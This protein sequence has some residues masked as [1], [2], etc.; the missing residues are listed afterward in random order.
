MGIDIQFAGQLIGLR[1][2]VPASGDAVMLGRQSIHIRPRQ[3]GRLRRLLRAGGLSDD[4]SDYLQEDGFS[5]RFF[6]AIGYPAMRSMDASGYEG[7]DHV[8]DLN[9]PLAAAHRGAFDLVIDGGTIEHV[10]NAPQALDSVFH[11]LRDGGVFISINGMTGWPGHGF[12]QF[13]P[14]LV[15]RYWGQA[16]GCEVLRCIA[17]P[18]DPER[19]IVDAPDTAVAGQRFR[20]RGLD[21]R[22]Y[23]FYAVRKPAGANP[24]ERV[25]EV[26]Q[27]D[28]A[29]RW[30]RKDADPEAAGA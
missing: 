28:Y 2:V 25:T 8:Q 18:F 29:V 20:G 9:A 12:Y 10:F 22:W 24:A 15:W 13:S 27:G 23:L 11:M 16:R 14:D 21:G 7:C 26:A 3:Y 1:D 6:E 4:V 5:E 17:L 19:G 30:S